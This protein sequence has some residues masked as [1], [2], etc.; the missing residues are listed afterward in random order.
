MEKEVELTERQ[1]AFLRRICRCSRV[2]PYC[3]MGI[4]EEIDDCPVLEEMGLVDVERSHGTIWFVT[5]TKEGRRL[6]KRR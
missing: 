2:S 3:I 6:A 4:A 1:A 5:G